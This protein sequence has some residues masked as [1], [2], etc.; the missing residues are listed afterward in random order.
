MSRSLTLPR[1]GETMEEGR[2]VR[3]L[4]QAGESYRRG[5]V[6]LEVET[7]KTTVEVPA[8]DDGALIAILAAEGTTVPVDTAI[9][10]I[11]GGASSSQT[12]SQSAAAV[13]AEAASKTTAPAA[14]ASAIAFRADHGPRASPAARRLARAAG[15]DLSTVDGTGR[16]GRVQGWDIPDRRTAAEPGKGLAL[17][18]WPVASPAGTTIALIHGFGGDALGFDRLARALTALGRP[19]VAVDLPAHGDSP[20]ATLSIEAI[21]D[22]VVAALATE[23]PIHLVGHS[24]GGAI[25][26]LAATRLKPTA[27]TLLAPVGFSPAIAQGFLDGL[28]HAETAEAVGALLAL[29][30]RDALRYTPRIL[31]AVATKLADPTVRSARV[32]LVRQLAEKGRQ[33][34]DLRA[35]FA[36]LTCPTTLILGRHDAIIPVGGLIEGLPLTAQHLLDTGHMPHLEAT[37]AVASIL[38]RS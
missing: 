29:T 34:R 36:A 14:K 35:D 8:L 27:V 16:Q 22:R 4:K 33:I 15:I 12:A 26:T 28:A 7:D 25:A 18:R 10:T 30:T 31:A 1:L 6:L 23:G 37:R 38:T 3:W 32:D 2:I 5:D 19:V 17:R 20:A 11:A 13:P 24:L 21:A 9:A